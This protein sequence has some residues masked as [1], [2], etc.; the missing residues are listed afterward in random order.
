MGLSGGNILSF[1]DHYGS[2]IRKAGRNISSFIFQLD[3]IPQSAHGNILD[4]WKE[5]GA[6]KGDRNKLYGR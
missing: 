4:D 3:E 1:S 5:D 6:M 2:V